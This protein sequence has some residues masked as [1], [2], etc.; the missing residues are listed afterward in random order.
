MAGLQGAE[1]APPMLDWLTD[2][3]LD[4]LARGE[5]VGAPALQFLLRRYASHARDDVIEPLGAAFA[6]EVHRRAGEGP[7]DDPDGWMAVFAEAAAMSDDP[8]LGRA[9]IDLLQAARSRWAG[10]GPYAVDDVTRAVEGC[11]LCV[12]LPDA[13][14]LAA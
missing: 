8:R 3:I 6:V 1:L 7:P 10:A 11:L 14:A 13:R 2:C 12:N 5:R 9:A 4:A